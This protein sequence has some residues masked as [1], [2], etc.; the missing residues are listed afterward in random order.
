M[1]ALTEL[2]ARLVAIPS[3]HS[4]PQ[5]I[6]RC[7]DFIV[8]WLDAHRIAYSKQIHKGVPTIT[9]LPET[10]RTPILLMS[11]IDVVEAPPAL[12]EP[13]LQGG[14]LYGRGTIDDKYAVA[15]SLRLLHD[16]LERLRAEGR[17]QRDLSFGLMITGDEEVGGKNGARPALARLEA[18][19]A[20]ALDGGCLD[21]IIIKEKGILRL[22]L[23]SRG[24]AAHGARPWLGENAIEALFRDYEILRTHFQVD[25]PDHWHRTLNWSVV[26]AGPSVNQVPDRAKAIFD[27]RYTEQDDPDALIAALRSALNGEL[28]ILN[29][30]PVF[31]AG[32]SPYMDRLKQIVPEAEWGMEHG[33]SDARFLAANGIP[34]VVWGADGNMSQHTDDEHVELDSVT[35]LYRHLDRFLALTGRER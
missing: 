6:D 19:F 17:S 34:G 28:E 8:D 27:I 2:L 26:E 18:D 16:H 20:I 12:F 7:A 3:T 5:E 22:K 15:L 14:R 9:A 21:R 32:S 24:R 30:D 29:L 4:R 35:I 11:H 23:T 33:A 31:E 1:E 13:R 25:A 10:D